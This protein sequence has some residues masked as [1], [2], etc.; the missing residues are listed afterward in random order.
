MID[1]RRF[2]AMSSLGLTAIAFPEAAWSQALHKL[3]RLVVGFPP[4]GSLDVV[5]RLLAEQLKGY[6]ESVVVEN[7]PGA[8]GRIALGSLKSSPAD[9]TTILLT[10]GDQLSLFPHI[11]TS[12]P[13]DPQ[14]DF[15]TVSTVCTVQF[16]LAVGPMVPSSVDTLQS[17]LSWCRANPKLASF[18]TAGAGTRQHMIGEALSRAAG[19][20]LVHVPY[21]GAPPAMQDLLAGQ[22]AANIAVISTALSQIQTGQLRGLMTSAPKRSAALPQVPTAREAGFP[23]LEAIEAFGLL[24]PG[25]TPPAIVEA[26]NAATQQ[27]LVSPAL[28]EGLAKLAL[29]PAG[30]TPGEYTALIMSDTEKWS[31]IVRASGFKPMD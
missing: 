11:Y 7:R 15:A 6:A 1:R 5:A 10:P 23:D 27:A 26:L 28:R 25:G 9:G 17:F 14:K 13:Y 3:V 31:G 20:E 18:G 16:L 4:G 2:I 21:K 19:V 8:G 12:L 22:I 29:E 30:S 24:L